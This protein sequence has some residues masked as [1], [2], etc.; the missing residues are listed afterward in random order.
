MFWRITLVWTGEAA[1]KPCKELMADLP[2]P[3]REARAPGLAPGKPP[4]GYTLP[5]FPASSTV[6]RRRH[7]TER[8][9]SRAAI[10]PCI[11]LDPSMPVHANF[12]VKLNRIF[13][14]LCFPLFQ[15][16]IFQA[17]GHFHGTPAEHFNYTVHAWRHI[18]R[19]A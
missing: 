18:M 8:V 4:P 6:P 15:V 9:L 13:L 10:E 1:N 5:T 12:F 17:S 19:Q 11:N 16:G 2:L 3:P 14:Q 7:I